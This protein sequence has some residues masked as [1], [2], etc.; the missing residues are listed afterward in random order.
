MARAL[1]GLFCTRALSKSFAQIAKFSM[2][3]TGTTRAF[4]AAMEGSTNARGRAYLTRIPFHWSPALLL[5]ASILGCGG[6][7]ASGPPQLP[8]TNIIVAVAP[9]T[10]S[11]LLG[12]SWTFTATVSNTANTAVTWSVNG[13]PGGNAA[14]GTVD[15]SGVYTAPANLPA[16]VTVSVQATSTADTS[17]TSASL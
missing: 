14:A 17:I 5:V 13:I 2:D 3:H 7:V 8:P 15:A 11:V 4:A 12:D 6:L 10:T 9:A 1:R 16:P